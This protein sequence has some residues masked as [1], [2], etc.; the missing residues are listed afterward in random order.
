MKPVGGKER[1]RTVEGFAGEQVLFL[2]TKHKITVRQ[3]HCGMTLQKRSIYPEF[4][5]FSSIFSKSM[6]L[7][8][9]ILI[10]LSN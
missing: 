2:D 1:E 5:T 7:F 3:T 4:L 9:A 6:V 8:S 10:R